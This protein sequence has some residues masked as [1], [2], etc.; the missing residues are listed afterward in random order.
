MKLYEEQ[1]KT[2][3]KDNNIEAEHLSFTESCHSVEEAAAVAHT[4]PD[5]FVKNICMISADDRLIVAIVKG[6]DRVSA[7][8]VGAVLKIEKPRMAKPEEILERTGYICGG[9]PSFGYEATFLVDEKV[10]EKDNVFT[11]GGSE[12]SLVKINPREMLRANHGD[13]VTIRK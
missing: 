1:L 8:L 13:I 11:G 5:N 4:S 12:N 7:E 6:E 10:M 9:T 3:L 2:Y